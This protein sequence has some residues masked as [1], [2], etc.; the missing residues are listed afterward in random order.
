MPSREARLA[1]STPKT[2]EQVARLRQNLAAPNEGMELPALPAEDVTVKELAQ[3]LWEAIPDPLRNAGTIGLVQSA[4][5]LHKQILSG[6]PKVTDT[7]EI[8]HEPASP[9]V[10]GQ[11]RQACN[12]LGI[13]TVSR[14][15]LASAAAQ[16]EDT[17]RPNKFS[18]LRA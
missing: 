9:A 18:D 3:L 8:I 2:P 1:L 15:R 16:L 13:S 7:G 10:Y 14:L 17:R 12:D 6:V 11:F 5:M 4:A